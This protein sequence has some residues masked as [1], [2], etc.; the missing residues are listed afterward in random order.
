MV[1]KFFVILFLGIFVYFLSNNFIIKPQFETQKLFVGERF[2]NIVISN[3]GNIIASWGKKNVVIRKSLDSGKTYQEK[4]IITPGIH[5]GGL[6]VDCK[7]GEIILFSQSTHPPSDILVYK[8][9]DEGDTWSKDNIKINLDHNKN[10]PQLHMSEKGICLTGKT[11]A[12]RLIRP[13]RVYGKNNDGYNLAIYSDDNGKNF[14]SSNQF[15]IM[16]SGE[17]AIVE[18]NNGTLYYTSRKHFFSESDEITFNRYSAISFDGGQTWKEPNLSK[19]LPDG[20]RYRGLERKGSSFSGHFGLMSG[21]AKVDN[22]KHDILIYSNVD[23]KSHIRKNLTVW[24]SFDGGKSWPI[25]K[26]IFDGYSAYS[27]LVA[28]K[29]SLKCKEWIYILY[30]AGEKKGYEFGLVSRFNLQWILTGEL[31]GDGELPLNFNF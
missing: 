18:L 24:A 29:K 26:K 19:I 5:G 25:K 16:G 22:E 9:S 1:Y 3:K 23:S 10:L 6:T 7:T 15:P 2:P 31:T 12:G 20:P 30:E 14:L 21:L 11:F 28:C 27:S 17:G 13:A 8:S 4:K